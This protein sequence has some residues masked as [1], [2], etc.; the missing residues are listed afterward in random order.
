MI[1]HIVFWK[2]KP[3]AHGNNAEHNGRAIKRMLSAL[4]P[5]IPQ[6][7]RLSVGPDINRSPAAWDLAL[8]TVFDSPKDLQTYQIH[9]EHQK[10]VAFI[11]EAASARAVVDF[12]D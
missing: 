8:D 9:P 3:Q 11:S 7:R 6:V 12:E 1:H 10:V 4:P 2:L 5:L